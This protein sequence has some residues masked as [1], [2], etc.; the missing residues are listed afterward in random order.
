MNDFLPA[1]MKLTATFVMKPLLTFQDSLWGTMGGSTE[2]VS[3][4]S[5][6]F[7]LPSSFTKATEHCL[8]HLSDAIRGY[9]SPVF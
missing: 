8:E 1:F 3:V 9:F 7:M 6:I 2:N 5:T 4:F